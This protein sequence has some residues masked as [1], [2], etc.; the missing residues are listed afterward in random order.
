[1]KLDVFTKSRLKAKVLLT[2]LSK[3]SKSFPECHLELLT[4][5]YTDTSTDESSIVR[6]NKNNPVFSL[7]TDPTKEFDDYELDRIVP[8]SVINEFVTT[9]IDEFFSFEITSR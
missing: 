4:K 9:T 5:Q 7:N 1:M 6:I 3:I 2:Y 8:K